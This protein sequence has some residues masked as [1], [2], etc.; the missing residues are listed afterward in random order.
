MRSSPCR[1]WQRPAIIPAG[2]RCRA[3]G[4]NDNLYLLD[5]IPWPFPFHFGGILSTVY[6]DLLSSVDLNTAGFGAQ[7]GDIMGCV[8]DARTRPGAKDRF[9]GQADISM[10]TA[11]GL[12]EGPLGL[13]DASIAVYGRRSYIDLL[14][15]KMFA[16]QGLTALPYF[17]DMGG[18]IDFTAGR[19]NH[20]KGIALANDDL[21]KTTGSVDTGNTNTVFSHGFQHGQRLLYRGVQLDKY[22]HR[23]VYVEDDSLLFQFI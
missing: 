2:S 6:S 19:D 14:L 10:L 12:L 15:G 11:Q 8:L 21:L 13:G 3:A 17:W 22:I 5:G 23:R 16:S 4:P 1:A 9:H 7:W 20:F 18:S